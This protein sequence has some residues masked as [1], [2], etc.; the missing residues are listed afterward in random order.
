MKQI[1]KGDIEQRMKASRSKLLKAKDEE[2][3]LYEVKV[4]KGQKDFID[5]L[6]VRNMLSSDMKVFD[7]SGNVHD[8]FDN[9][10]EPNMSFESNDSNHPDNPNNSYP[11][12]PTNTED[13]DSENADSEFSDDV[14][15]D[16]SDD[17]IN[18]DHLRN[19]FAQLRVTRETESM[20]DENDADGEYTY[21]VNEFEDQY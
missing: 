4:V 14:V 10:F 9:V 20:E 16:F 19:L 21:C 8:V 18:N 13:G 11:D 2:V 12:T 7:S 6:P 3:D 17:Q 1:R 15:N 5:T